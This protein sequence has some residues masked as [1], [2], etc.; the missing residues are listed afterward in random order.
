MRK[1]LIVA[2]AVAATAAF[3]NVGVAMAAP[4]NVS[5]IDAKFNPDNPGATATKGGLFVEATTLHRSASPGTPTNPLKEPVPTTNVDVSFDNDIVFTP[6]AV[7]ICN[8]A[9]TGTTQAGMQACGDAY[10]GGGYATICAALG[11]P[12][13]ACD[14]GVVNAQVS[15]YHGPN[16]PQPT[17]L[18]QGVADHTSVGPLTV[19][20]TGTLRSSN[21]PGEFAGG[22]RLDVPVPLIP[23]AAPGAAAIT[24][25]AVNV[26]N[27]AFVKASCTGDGDLDY[28]ARFE[29]A[30]GSPPSMRAN[31][32]Q[33]C[34]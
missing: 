8:N 29:Y 25:F 33:P 9:L 23:P 6:G 30:A 32:S 34:T 21:Q 12:G 13:T 19:V 2:A 16:N 24:D 14:L 26:N 27:G 17:V 22:K 18:M 1:Y 28:T 5:T 10:V 7:P 31:D 11:G 20:L 4:P 15:A 3:A